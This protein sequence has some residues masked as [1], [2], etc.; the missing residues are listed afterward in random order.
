VAANL[1]DLAKGFLTSQV[2]HRI[3]G[4][5]GESPDRV[6][7]A[8]DAGIPSILAGFLNMASSWAPAACSRC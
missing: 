1:I 3:S 2:V 4:E 7:K 8:I 6:E 5:L